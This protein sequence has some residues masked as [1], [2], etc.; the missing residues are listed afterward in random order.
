[1]KKK[2]KKP[3]VSTLKKKVDKIFSE[4]IRKRDKGRCY[5]CGKKKHWS[6]MQCGH[7]VSR[8][9]NNTR[10][11]EVN[12]HCQC[13]GCNIFK[14]GAM[15]VYALRLLD[16]YPPDI[17]EYLNEQKQIIKQWQTWELEGLIC[18]YQE[19]MKEL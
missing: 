1:M 15:D 5:T 13:V 2:K 6:L 4:F 3:K 12:C 7:Y 14:S 11:N 10:Y 8:V 18:L 16:E 19:K 17:L 9:H